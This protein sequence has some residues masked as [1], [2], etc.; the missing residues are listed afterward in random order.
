MANEIILPVYKMSA[1]SFINTLKKK[2]KNKKKLIFQCELSRI[3][4]NDSYFG[5]VG[6]PANKVNGKWEIGSRINLQIDNT[7]NPLKLLPPLIFGNNEI[8]PGKGG[9][10]KPGS[11]YKKMRALL[12]SKKSLKGLDLV[13]TP[14]TTK[15]PHVT[16]DVT[17]GSTSE[18]ANP[19]PPADPY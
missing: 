6:Y 1:A 9:K 5:L 13:F 16:Y 19:S 18:N 3:Y 12:K 15:N 4:K 8:L 2:A 14:K 10:K 11:I 17:I 7:Q